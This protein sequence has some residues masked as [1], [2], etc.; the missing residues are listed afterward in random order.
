MTS[1]I[2]PRRVMVLTRT[3]AKTEVKVQLVQKLNWTQTDDITDCNTQGEMTSHNLC[4]R[5]D[6]HFVGITR[7][8]LCS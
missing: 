7:N 3:H 2:N 6:R 1:T 4:S 5:Y 8:N